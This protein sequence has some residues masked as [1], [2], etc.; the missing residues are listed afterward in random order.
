MRPPESARTTK[1][2]DVIA[3]A[4]GERGLPEVLAPSPPHRSL[5]A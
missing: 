5:G 3:E 4:K 2:I 1:D